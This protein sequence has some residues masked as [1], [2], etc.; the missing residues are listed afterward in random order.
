MATI[1]ENIKKYRAKCG[2][3]QDDLVK[4]ADIKYST[5]TKIEGG[6]VKKPGVQIM[7]KIAKALGVSIEDL[8]K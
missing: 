3:T 4:K 1:G 8:M 2:L 5:L 6:V 7:A